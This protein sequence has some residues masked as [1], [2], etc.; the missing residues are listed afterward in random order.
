MFNCVFVTF[1]CGILG[2]VWYLILSIPESLPHFLLCKHTVFYTMQNNLS[3]G[4]IWVGPATSGLEVI[5][6][7]F[8]LKLKIKRN[9]WLLADTC[10]QAT[11]QCALFYSILY[12]LEAWSHILFS[13]MMIETSIASKLFPCKILQIFKRSGCV[14]ATLYFETSVQSG[15]FGA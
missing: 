6:L 14:N 7:S 11:N 3:K 5:K 1:P 13:G 15:H 4:F 9:Y 10:P 8:I 2:Q 12:N